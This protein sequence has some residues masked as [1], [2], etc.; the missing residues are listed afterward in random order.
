MATM[1]T[2]VAMTNNN[3]ALCMSALNVSSHERNNEA[4]KAMTVTLTVNVNKEAVCIAS[5]IDT[6]INYKCQ[7]IV[8]HAAE[9]I[10]KTESL[11]NGKLKVQN[12]QNIFSYISHVELGFLSQNTTPKGVHNHDS[13]MTKG[14]KFVKPNL[15]GAIG[16][17]D[18]N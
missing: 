7:L 18:I 4:T 11:I 16:V 15:A 6:T 13:T 10:K 17:L 1:T 9:E 8:E 2:K 14:R 5:N 12:R 3:Y